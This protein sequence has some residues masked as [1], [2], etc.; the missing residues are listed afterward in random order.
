MIELVRT[1]LIVL[2]WRSFDRDDEFAEPRGVSRC[3]TGPEE[4]MTLIRESCAPCAARRWLS[5]GPIAVAI[6]AGALVWST[7]VAVDGWK[8]SKR[9]AEEPTEKTTRPTTSE[10]AYA[11]VD[12][13]GIAQRHVDADHIS[14]RITGGS[15]G[16]NRIRRATPA[17]ACDREIT[18]MPR[19]ARGSCQR[20]HG[21]PDTGQEGQSTLLRRHS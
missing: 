6:F 2:A 17:G 21:W 18:C 4:L 3:P 19:G 12:A 15:T 8:A 14:W 20:D 9:S 13:V 10:E 7:L 16:Q 11:S 1:G 5:P